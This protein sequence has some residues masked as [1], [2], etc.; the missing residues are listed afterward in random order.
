[1]KN[2]DTRA[3]SIADFYEW[4]KNGLLELVPDFQRRTVWSEKA[5]SYLI[6][7]II[8]G[9]PIPKIL[10]SQR[11]QG[12]RTIRVVV[13]G[14]KTSSNSRIYKWRLRDFKSAQ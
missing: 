14:T 2:F 13:D 10:I 6:D 7:T 12:T 5:K 9:R 1:M 3:Y 8:R 4:Q 11:L